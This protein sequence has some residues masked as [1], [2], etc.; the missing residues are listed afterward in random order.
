MGVVHL[1]R[2]APRL[3]DQLDRRGLLEMALRALALASAC[4]V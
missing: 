1:F 3:L 2:A 4:F